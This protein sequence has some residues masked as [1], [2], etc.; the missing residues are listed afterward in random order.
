MLRRVVLLVKPCVQLLTNREV[1]TQ[2][3]FATLMAQP[4]LRVGHAEPLIRIT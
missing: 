1:T 3:V 4:R 2:Q